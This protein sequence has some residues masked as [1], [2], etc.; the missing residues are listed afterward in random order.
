MLV[1]P[2]GT[3]RR[4]YRQQR[5]GQPVDQAH[6]Q[7]ADR[8]GCRQLRAAHAAHLQALPGVGRRSRPPSQRH[9]LSWLRGRCNMT[10]RLA[11]CRR[12]LRQ[13]GRC[14]AVVQVH[15]HQPCSKATVERLALVLVP[16]LRHFIIGDEEPGRRQAD[17]RVVA[18]HARHL[19]HCLLVVLPTPQRRTQTSRVRCT[20]KW[21]SWILV[22]RVSRIN[23]AGYGCGEAQT[24]RTKGRRMPGQ[25]GRCT[26]KRTA[27]ARKR[28]VRGARLE[29]K[30]NDPARPTLSAVFS[31]V[32]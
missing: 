20:I 14:R 22:V 21:S 16:G 18:L 12:E 28:V 23:S 5:V 32:F 19:L 17:A 8:H 25:G 24:R 13:E 10:V 31:A 6:R 30:I 26:K 27:G 11:C 3:R 1:C 2:P 7:A 9:R 15:L 29:G 4:A